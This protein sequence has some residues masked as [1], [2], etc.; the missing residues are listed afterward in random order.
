VG[1]DYKTMAFTQERVY[2]QP[3]ALG[4]LSL[5]KV[6][7]NEEDLIQVDIVNPGWKG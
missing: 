3:I 7:S 1:I 4:I 5:L 6:K 2:L